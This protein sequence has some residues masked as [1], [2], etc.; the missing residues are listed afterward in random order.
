MPDITNPATNITLNAK[1]NEVK[2]EVA[3]ITNSTTT[4]ALDA[5]INEFK[6]KIPNITNLATIL[7]L[8]LLKIKY[9]TLVIQSKKTDYN[10]KINEIEKKITD[11]DHDRYITSPEIN[12]LTSL[13]QAILANKSHITNFVRK[14][15]F[16][17]KLKNCFK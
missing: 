15:D 12:K 7:L 3:S 9:L 11:Y 2:G 14:K 17:D 10:R 6:G 5:K 13:A 8:L 16:D 1:I 4:A